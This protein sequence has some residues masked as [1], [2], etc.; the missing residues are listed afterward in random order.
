MS[1]HIWP[2]I[3]SVGWPLKRNACMCRS[4]RLDC[5]LCV[6]ALKTIFAPWEQN[7]NPI[8]VLAA[9]GKWKS[10]PS[11]WMLEELICANGART[12]H[13]KLY[14]LAF[15]YA[16]VGSVGIRHVYKNM[17]LICIM[18]TGCP[19]KWRAHLNRGYLRTF[20]K[21]RW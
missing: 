13:L 20:L 9:N 11:P 1:N 16:K 10:E 2:A 4:S 18:Y 3:Y 5:Q 17:T 21:S 14:A 8:G 15:L 12:T 6:R 19:I 7:H